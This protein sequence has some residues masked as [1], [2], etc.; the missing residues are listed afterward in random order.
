MAVNDTAFVCSNKVLENILCR[1]NNQRWVV[2]CEGS[3][4]TCLFK[5]ILAEVN[6][7]KILRAQKLRIVEKHFPISLE[8]ELPLDCTVLLKVT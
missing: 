6:F 1:V 8:H 7:T 2:E 3:E 4:L 5:I